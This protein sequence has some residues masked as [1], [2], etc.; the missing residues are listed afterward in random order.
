MPNYENKI[1]KLQ[2]KIGNIEYWYQPTAD[3]QT[4]GIILQDWINGIRPEL[5]N[6]FSNS[7][8]KG[9]VIQA[10][11]NFGL[12]PVLYT[13]FFE[14]V[15]TFEPDPMNFFCLGLNCQFNNIIKMNLALGDKPG[16]A[17]MINRSPVN[18]GMNCIEETSS[19][20]NSIPIVNIDSF[21]FQ[22]V[23]LLQLD[24]E[25]YELPALQ[26]AV[27]TINKYKP[28]MII[29]ATEEW[30]PET[31]KPIVDFLDTLGYKPTK[32]ITRLDTVFTYQG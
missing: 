13:E 19:H 5:L 25:G 1:G 9:T 11:G 10:G 15:Y 12:Y 18:Y 26:G 24:L 6:H 29:E 3:N 16:N 14:T 23:R 31:Y 32:I 22:D 2:H 20:V 27:N 7:D 30:S 8:P 17:R 28:L 21:D 4:F